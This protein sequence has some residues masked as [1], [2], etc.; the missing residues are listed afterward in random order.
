M[1]TGRRAQ[2]LFTGPG[3]T[4]RIL[5]AVMLACTVATQHPNPAF[6]RLQRKDTLSLLPN[7]RFFAPTPAMHDHHLLYRTLDESGETSVW[8]DI[9][10]I[11]GRK[12]SQVVWFATRRQEKAVFDVCA[13]ILRSLDKGFD[14]VVNLPAYRVLVGYIR[15]RMVVDGFGDAEGFQFT[16]VRAAGYDDAEEPAA[17]FISPYA[18]LK[19]HADSLHR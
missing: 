15:Q 17:L 7:W 1:R 6:N 3:S 14:Y 2:N 12:M 11:A 5:G 19:N 4:V 8:R 13:E 10:V 16:L 9:D 18:R